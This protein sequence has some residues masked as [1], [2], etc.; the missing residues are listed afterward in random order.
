MEVG[1]SIKDRG[2]V[3]NGLQVYIRK[4][5]SNHYTKKMGKLVFSEETKEEAVI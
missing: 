1:V 4:L 5:Q 2:E 3:K